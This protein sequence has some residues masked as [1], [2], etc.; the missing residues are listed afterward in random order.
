LITD[1]NPQSVLISLIFLSASGG[2]SA[3]LARAVTQG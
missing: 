2:D 1:P 3:R